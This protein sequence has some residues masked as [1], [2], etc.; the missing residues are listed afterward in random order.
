MNWCKKKIEAWCAT[1]VDSSDELVP[2]QWGVC[3]PACQ[4]TKLPNDKSNKVV[5]DSSTISIAIISITVLILLSIIIIYCCYV[6]SNKGKEENY[7]E[8]EGRSFP[9]GIVIKWSDIKMD[10]IIGEGNFGKVYQ[11]Y[12]YLNE[13]QR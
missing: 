7:V 5:K 4:P 3:E 13:I 9:A 11:G 6:K 12:L 1:K 8:I 10:S 2:G